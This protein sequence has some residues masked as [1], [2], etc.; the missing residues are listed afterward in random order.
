M[1]ENTTKQ[2][3]LIVYSG[4]SGVGKGTIMPYILKEFPDI[5]FSVSATTRAPRPGETNGVE[6]FFVSH[7]DFQQMVEDDGFLEYAQFCDNF[8]GT[9]KKAVEDTLSK[10]TSVILEIEVQG[11]ANVIGKVPDCVSIFILPPS[12]E[13]LERRLRKRGTED[14]ETILKRVSQAS[15]ELK[16]AS[17]YKYNVVNDDLETAIDEVIAILRKELA[18]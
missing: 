17:I 14:E 9:P 8:Y 11:G 1:S 3:K 15:E 5:Q 10:G 4:C 18:E 6:Y 12:I 2:G 7:E 16:S 13:E